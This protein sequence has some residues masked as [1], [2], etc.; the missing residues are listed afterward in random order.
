MAGLRALHTSRGRGA[1]LLLRNGVTGPKET[2]GASLLLRNG[3]TGTK[4]AGG[5]SLLLRNA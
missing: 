3:V 4:E 2:G 5:A 1:S